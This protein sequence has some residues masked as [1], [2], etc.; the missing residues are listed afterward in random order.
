MSGLLFTNDQEYAVYRQKALQQA[1]ARNIIHRE[2]LTYL[3]Q[4]YLWGSIMSRRRT[5]EQINSPQGD[6]MNR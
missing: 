3:Y 1:E 2:R 4:T 5:A 6:T